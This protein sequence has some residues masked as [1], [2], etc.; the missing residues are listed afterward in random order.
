MYSPLPSAKPLNFIMKP[1][2][3]YWEPVMVGALDTY[4]LHYYPELYKK[5]HVPIHYILIIGYDEEKQVVY[6]HDCSFGGI[7]QI[8]YGELRMRLI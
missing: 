1:E 5:E 7:Q 3:K 8:S 4:Y 6:V 2:M